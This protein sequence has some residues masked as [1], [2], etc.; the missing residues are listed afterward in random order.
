GDQAGAGAAA[1]VVRA[2]VLV[3]REAPLDLGAAPVAGVADQVAHVLVVLVAD[4][5]AAGV[6]GVE[7][8]HRR[9]L[10]VHLGADR[11]LTGV[12]VPG[13]AGR[14]RVVAQRRVTDDAGAE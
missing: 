7:L 9:I 6:L 14:Q 1:A 5:G 13:D 8:P 3:E 11:V 4:P 2:H 10:V 12:V